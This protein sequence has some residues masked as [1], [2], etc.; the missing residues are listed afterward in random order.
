MDV[1]RKV[2][3]VA[4]K[5]V[6]PIELEPELRDAFVAAAKSEDRPASQVLRELIRD[7]V[8]RQRAAAEYDTFLNR[9][10]AAAR[11]SRD[12][13]CGQSNDAVEAAFA[14]R[15]AAATSQA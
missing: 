10:V 12:A 5:A 8:Q 4:D 11:S 14:A 9:K 6:F 13:G 2:R 15:R 3:I 7:Y 1:R